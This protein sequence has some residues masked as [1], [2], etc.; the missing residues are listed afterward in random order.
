MA[1]YVYSLWC[2]SERIESLVWHFEAVVAFPDATQKELKVFD[3]EMERYG[4]PQ[5]DATQK[6]LK[7]R[8]LLRKDAI[9][10]WCNSERIERWCLLI[11][12]FQ[13]TPSFLMQLRKNWKEG[14]E[15]PCTAETSRCNSERIESILL[16]STK[17]SFLV[18]LMQL[19]KNWKNNQ[20]HRGG[21]RRC[22]DWM[23][24]RKNWKVW[25][26]PWLL[27][28]HLFPM[29][30]RKNWKLWQSISRRTLDALSRMQLRKNWKLRRVGGREPR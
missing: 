1:Q 15:P 24:L 6:E 11:C 23:Q 27:L 20:G 12:L 30:L 7:G 16:I 22:T 5:L 14:T 19:R 28:A 10:S 26:N 4:S 13:H 21:G 25:N 3:R 18:F 2:N 9:C 8:N 29:Q 17:A